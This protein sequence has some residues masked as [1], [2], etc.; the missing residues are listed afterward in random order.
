MPTLG[1]PPL[2]VLGNIN[3]S[4]VQE[5]A[6][7]IQTDT[8]LNV[9]LRLS[10]LTASDSAAKQLSPTCL[11]GSLAHPPYLLDRTSWPYTLQNFVLM[12]TKIE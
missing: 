12:F 2:P 7:T 4:I 11:H 5:I 1:M 9:Q 6:S 3:V 8:P 10:Q